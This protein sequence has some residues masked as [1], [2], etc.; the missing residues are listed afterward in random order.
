MTIIEDDD[1]GRKLLTSFKKRREDKIDL[2]TFDFL[3]RNITTDKT[4]VIN[5]HKLCK[6]S[7]K[8]LK[9]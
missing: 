4:M 1:E 7:I 8:F 3:R 2:I 9:N 5:A 6:T